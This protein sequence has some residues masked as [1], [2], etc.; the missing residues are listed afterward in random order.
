MILVI[1]CRTAV[2]T[3]QLSMSASEYINKCNKRFFR[4][5]EMK[6]QKMN[7]QESK[8]RKFEEK[9]REKG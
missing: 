1:S 8:E 7:T 4:L 9:I 3:E 2:F 6:I 5:S